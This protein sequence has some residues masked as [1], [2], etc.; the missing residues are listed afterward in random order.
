M[1]CNTSAVINLTGVDIVSSEDSDVL[2]RATDSASGDANVNS[3]WG[4][5]GGEVTFTA[6]AQTLEGTVSCNALSAISMS[7][8]DGSTLSGDVQIETGGEVNLYLESSTWTATADSTV[9]AP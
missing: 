9:T 3:D 1:V 8:S 7:L 5:A 2:I 6:S 4:S